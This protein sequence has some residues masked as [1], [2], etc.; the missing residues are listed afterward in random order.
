[1]DHTMNLKYFNRALRK[2]K[3]HVISEEQV[4][5]ILDEIKNDI[6]EKIQNKDK[7]DLVLCLRNAIGVHLEQNAKT[8]ILNGEAA[9]ELIEQE[10]FW[11]IQAIK[12]VPASKEVSAR[13][14]GGL[15][16]L[17]LL[18]DHQE[19]AELIYLYA[20]NMLSKDREYYSEEKTHHVFMTCLYYKW[21]TGEMPPLFDIL[22]EDHIYQRLMKNWYQT[23]QLAELLYEVC[24]FHI[25]SAS[26]TPE[27]NNEILLFDH[28]PYDYYC[29][30]L[31]REKEG[32]ETPNIEHPLLQTALAN[33]PTS[34]PGY[35]PE[36]DE[37][38][39]Y[40]LRNEKVPDWQRI[41]R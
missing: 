40:V 33:I 15:I 9:W 12:S 29:I 28:I 6:D 30:K 34:S 3:K 37:I 11:L 17:S 21:K 8:K 35:N 31:V 23:D 2:Y 19:I 32:L 36:T 27:K 1:M 39:Q 41:I 16:G 14:L 7:N 20:S 13:E 26:D 5:E 10:V 24:E 4:Q 22:P 25:Y 38:L 18:W